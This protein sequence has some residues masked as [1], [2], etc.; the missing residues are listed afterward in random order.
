MDRN[1]CKGK[2]CRDKLK[3]ALLRLSLEG[4]SWIL[5]RFKVEGIDRKIIAFFYNKNMH[6]YGSESVYTAW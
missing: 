2:K 1:N 4:F 6:G 5:E 3:G